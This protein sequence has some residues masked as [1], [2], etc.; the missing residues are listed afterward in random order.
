MFK[1]WWEKGHLRGILVV[2]KHLRGHSCG[3]GNVLFGK[4]KTQWEQHTKSFSLI[5]A[6]SFTVCYLMLRQI[7]LPYSEIDTYLINV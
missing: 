5:L 6:P 2:F 7:K 4:L 1:V 3:K